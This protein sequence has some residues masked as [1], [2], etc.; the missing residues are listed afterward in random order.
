MGRTKVIT[1]DELIAYIDRF[2][3][4]KC[5]GKVDMLKIP[6]LGEFIRSNGMPAVNDTV[7]RRNK[8][9]RKYI[10]DLKKADAS[11]DVYVVSTYKTL[12]VD[13]FIE[14]NHSISN[15]KKSLTEL[16]TYYKKVSEAATKI[17]D[18]YKKLE[19]KYNI[20]K[21]EQEKIS[22]KTLQSSDNIAA[23]MKEN[24]SLKE[25]NKALRTI[26]DT[27]V[28]PEIANELLK[29]SGLLYNTEEVVDPKAID[30]NIIRSDTKIKSNSNIIKGMFNKFKE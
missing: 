7:I 20:L 15:L 29:Q 21:K 1:D 3:N 24:N 13:A 25:E 23:L 16:N 14:R 9:A 10:D 22:N 12:D 4:E 30:E 26:I 18:K 19:Q 27:Y 6:V 8:A 2:L 11:E 28:Y 5:A 17:S